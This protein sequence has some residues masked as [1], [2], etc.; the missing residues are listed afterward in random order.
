MQAM[1]HCV[2][3]SPGCI[4]LFCVLTSMSVK[5]LSAQ[6]DSSIA[7]SVENRRHALLSLFDE[8]WQY[9]LRTSSEGA[10][11]L[12]DNR[13]NDRLSDNS[14]EF[15][16]SDLEQRR[17]FLAR[18]DAIDPGGFSRQDT[19]SRELMIR[20]LRLEMEGAQFKDWEMPVNQMGGLHLE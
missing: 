10:T 17:R 4:V 15:F 6:V 13:Y 7:A 14:P 8:E 12:G 5:P 3:P 18:F 1:I 2:R 20:K 16:R 19:L 11:M 9:E